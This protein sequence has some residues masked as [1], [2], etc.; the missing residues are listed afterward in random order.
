MFTRNTAKKEL[1]AIST[2]RTT[3]ENTQTPGENTI[4]FNFEIKTY[5]QI[6][7]SN[8]GW[9][10]WKD[11]EAA[12]YALFERAFAATRCEFR[13]SDSLDTYSMEIEIP[14]DQE[15]L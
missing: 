9:I 12:L 14:A 6:L 15:V 11:R 8:L 10:A 4:C 7:L 5:L 3:L 2:T 13:L 1:E